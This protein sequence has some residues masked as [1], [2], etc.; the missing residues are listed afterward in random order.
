V[1]AP[2]RGGTG[3]S[4]L[5]V[6]KG[7]GPGFS[8]DLGSRQRAGI[9]GVAAEVLQEEGD[10][11]VGADGVDGEDLGAGSYGAEAG[12]GNDLL[13]DGLL[14]G[15]H[16]GGTG[17][18]KVERG[19]LQA[20]K[21]EAGAARVDLVRGDAAEYLSDGVLDGGAVF[22]QREVEGGATALP[23]L[24]IQDKPAGG[25]VVVAELFPAKCGAGAATAVD[26]NVAAMEALRSCDWQV[27]HRFGAPPPFACD[28]VKQRRPEAR[29]SSARSA[30]GA[31]APMFPALCISFHSSWIRESLRQASGTNEIF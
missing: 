14:D 5:E 30:I 1:D 2:R 21:E 16:E 29:T 8:I 25:V 9:G 4:G 26:E 20:V 22:G 13:D 11:A 31:R 12:I 7:G 17:A 28:V 23:G 6:W 10:E 3:G 27:S 18:G 19:D 24:W 15:L